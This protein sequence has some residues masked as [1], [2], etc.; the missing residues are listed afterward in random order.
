[1]NSLTHAALL[2]PGYGTISN[3]PEIGTGPPHTLDRITH[4]D[5]YMNNVITEVQDG[6]KQKHQVFD[7]TV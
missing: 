6:S 7:G 4:I 3:I 2:V 1:M 5:C